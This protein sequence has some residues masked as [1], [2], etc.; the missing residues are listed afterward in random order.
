MESFFDRVNHDLLMERVGREVEDRRLLKL[1]RRYLKAGLMVDGA[2]SPRLEGTPRGG[3]LSPLLSNVLL[4]D[5]DCEL[6]WR[7]H[8]FVRYADDVVIH[9]RSERA[10]TSCATR[11]PA[12][13]FGN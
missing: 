10:G 12:A 2:H 8:R 7:G 9:V 11:T 1:I 5:L 4:T 13:G 3:P 6:E